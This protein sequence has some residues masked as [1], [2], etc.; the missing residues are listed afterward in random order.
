MKK[1]ILSVLAIAA[2][3][4]FGAPLKEVYAGE[5]LIGTAL[6]SRS[7][8]H[9]YVYPMRKDARELELA[10]QEFNCITPENLMKMEYLQPKEGFFNFE[11][12]DEFMALAEKNDLVVVGHA[13]VWHS[14]VPDWI[15]KDRAGNPVSRSVLIERMRKHIHTVVGRYKGR[16][17]YWDVVN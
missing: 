1:M 7:I 2:L 14:Q 17:K 8:N 15:F 10:V 5:F 13:L 6:G 16:I 12:A 3:P 9:R 4:V 11:Q